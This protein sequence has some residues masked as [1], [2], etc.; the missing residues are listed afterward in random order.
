M[1]IPQQQLV[2]QITELRK[3]HGTR[4][5]VAAMARSLKYHNLPGAEDA[6]WSLEGVTSGC[7]HSILN[8]W[9]RGDEGTEA[10]RLDDKD[11]G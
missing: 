10:G 1:S 4:N 11:P 6:N 9:P 7:L 2:D 8:H 3:Q 5:V